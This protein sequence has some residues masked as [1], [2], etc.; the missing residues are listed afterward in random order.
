MKVTITQTCNK[1]GQ[2]YHAGDTLVLFPPLAQYLIR[3]GVAR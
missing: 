1:H 2:L 3:M